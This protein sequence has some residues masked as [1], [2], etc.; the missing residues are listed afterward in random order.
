MVYKD[1]MKPTPLEIIKTDCHNIDLS[2]WAIKDTFVFFVEDILKID[3]EENTPRQQLRQSAHWTD[4][5]HQL[6]W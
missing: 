5:D 6:C 4:A 3:S 1:E 2:Y